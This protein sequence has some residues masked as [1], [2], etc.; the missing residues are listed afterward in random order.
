MTRIGIIL[1]STRPGR[2]GDQVAAWVQQVAVTRT[3]AEFELLDLIDYSLPHLDEE[4]PPA[5]DQYSQPHTL[6]WAEKIASFDGFI[7]VTPEYNHFTSG[8]MKDALDFL[9]KEWNNKAV[10]FVGYGAYGGSRAIDHLRAVVAELAMA[11]V[12]A[13][14]ALHLATDFENFSIFRPAER[15]TAELHKVLDETIA[16]SNALVPLRLPVHA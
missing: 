4:V 13:L 5:M 16:W 6:A 10:G 1:G 12:R 3:D 7:I 15:H 14:V 2:V 8:A 9:N 11:D